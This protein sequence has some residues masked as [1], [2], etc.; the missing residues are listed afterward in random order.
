MLLVNII[1]QILPERKF[2]GAEKASNPVIILEGTG[3]ILYEKFRE[4]TVGASG[5]S[6]WLNC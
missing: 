2:S 5:Y 3:T 6:R 1:N 4:Y